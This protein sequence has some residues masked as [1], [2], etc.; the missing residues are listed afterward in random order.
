MKHIHLIAI[1][2]SAMHNFALELHELGYKITGSDDQIFD[3]SKSRLEK[4]GLLPKEMGWFPERIESSIDIVILGMHAKPDNPELKKAQDLGLNIMSYPEFLFSEHNTKNRVVIGGSHGKTTTT[5]MILHVLNSY[6]PQKEVDYMVGAQLKGFD[7]MVKINPEANIVVLEGDEYLSS[8]IDMRSKF[9]W[10]KPQ[11]AVLTGIAWDHINVFPTFESYLETFRAFILTIENGGTLVY[12]SDDKILTQLVEETDHNIVKIPYSYHDY[13]I[14]EGVTT[15]HSANADYPIMFFGKHN[16]M[17]FNA[18]K[19]ILLKLGLSE[20]EI[21]TSIQNF[22]G[23]DKRLSR[24]YANKDIYAFKDFAH[25]PSKVEA[26]VN[27]VKEQ[28]T[29]F[30]IEV[31]LELHTYSSLNKD[32]IPH[33]KDSLKGLHEPVLYFSKKA[34]EIKRMPDLDS[35]EVCEAFNKSDLLVIKEAESLHKEVNK[36]WLNKSDKTVFLFMSSGNYGGL[37]LEKTLV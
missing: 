18:A 33:Y 9:L 1:G 8:P 21:L 6:F 31:F 34:L 14:N 24:I 37:V 22:E 19:H 36:R 16:L 11:L 15:L 26:C 30:N 32:F 3:P 29:G 25:S 28:F 20:V 4:A 35:Q 2:G 10:Y 7:R 13:S 5:S 12:N 17:N 27:A 23:A